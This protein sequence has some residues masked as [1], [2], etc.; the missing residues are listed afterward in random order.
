MAGTSGPLQ[1]QRLAPEAGDVDRG[2]LVAVV[3]R[4]AVAAN[5]LPDVEILLALWPRQGLAARAGLRGVGFVHL[6]EGHSCVIA[7]V[8]EEAPQHGQAR[9]VRRLA[10]AGDDLPCTGDVAHEDR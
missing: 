5:P 3:F 4:A 8:P 1:A 7:F 9:V 6:G 2:V 10:V